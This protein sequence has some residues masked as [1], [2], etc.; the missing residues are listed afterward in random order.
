MRIDYFVRRALSALLVIAGVVTL[1]FFVV[2]LVPSDPAR[3]YAGA[4]ARPAQ[5]AAIRSQLG[6]DRPLV[7]QYVRY[8]ASLLRG[9]LGD[10]LKTKRSVRID[11]SLFLPATLELVICAYLLALLAGIPAGV[12]AGATEGS[13]FDRLTGAAAILGAAAPVFALAL[14]AQQ[15]FF[16]H[17]HWL[18]LNGR[19]SAEVSINHP[20]TTLTGFWLLDTALTG[21][22]VAWRDVAAHLLLPVLVLAVYPLAIILRMTR[23]QS[24]G[25]MPCATPSCRC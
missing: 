21:N 4:R 10:S 25:A 16:N 17:L 2:R 5:L 22:W 23:A 20:V 6:L 3:L 19:M 11:L 13:G 18:P 15:L 9:D 14:L 7:E 1:T 12:L 8:V 24:C